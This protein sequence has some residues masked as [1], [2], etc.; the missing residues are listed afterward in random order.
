[1][2]KTICGMK[3]TY[4]LQGVVACQLQGITCFCFGLSISGR[5][6]WGLLL[7]KALCL[8]CCQA[9]LYWMG[10]VL[11]HLLQSLMGTTDASKPSK[12]GS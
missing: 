11:L 8:V 7:R 6:L 4:R 12:A 5:G 3:F 10:T 2:Y 1:M 9:A